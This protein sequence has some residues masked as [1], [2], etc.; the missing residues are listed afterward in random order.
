MSHTTTPS[1][2]SLPRRV[3]RRTA[4]RSL[5]ATAL[6]AY[7]LPRGL[8][9]AARVAIAPP[10]AAV[11]A[12]IRIGANENPY[13]MGPAPL[14][15]IR[16]GLG[17]ANRYSSE[18]QRLLGDL[19]TLHG[20]PRE[21]IALAPGSGEILRAATAAFTSPTKSLVAASPTFEA[22]GRTAAM[23]GAP[24]HA[25]P[26]LASGSL[27]LSGMA[28][29]AAGAGL[30]FV[31]NPNNPTGG[32]SSAASIAEFVAGVRKVSKDAV[33]L[34]DEAYY[35]Y[36]DDPAYKTAVPLI[37]SDPG[38]IV[39][40]TFSKVYGM[41]GMRVG[42]AIGQPQ[43][44]AAMRKLM[45]Q[46]TMSN[47]SVLAAIAALGDRPH[48]EQQKALNRDARAFTRQAFASAGFTVMPSEANFVMVDVRREVGDVQAM[49]RQSGVVIARAFPPLTTCARISIGT[50]DEM[51]R[52]VD[53]MIPKLAAPASAMRLVD[54]GSLAWEG[55]CC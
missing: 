20:V 37:A 52:A 5:I 14:A 50:M 34:I 45:S 6:G 17:E 29:K 38:I 35:E 42:Y 23:V 47:V 4:G 8:E 26:V 19:A 43:T 53:V 11:G 55:E 13:G 32:A 16:D 1:P 39:S 24:V 2:S 46:G 54:R 10:A 51:R 22:P 49:C 12:P 33:I 9:A 3:S 25:I 48:L 44:L 28:A 31:C 15:A 40:R 7:A 41:A 36:V 21:Q 18:A 27:D 30:F